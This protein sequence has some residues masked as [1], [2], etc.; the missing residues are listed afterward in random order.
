MQLSGNKR[1]MAGTLVDLRRGQEA[2]ELLGPVWH[3]DEGRNDPQNTQHTRRPSGTKRI[4]I[5]HKHLLNLSDP[6]HAGREVG[7]ILKD[8]LHRPC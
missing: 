1:K 6:P 7:L 4:A 2:E 3:E 5:S 8:S